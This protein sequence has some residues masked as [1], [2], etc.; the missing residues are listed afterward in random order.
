MK[1]FSLSTF[2]LL[3]TWCGIAAYALSRF[4]VERPFV[5]ST[6]DID[7]GTFPTQFGDI[8][9]DEATV[10]ATRP[11]EPSANNPPVSPRQVLVI[12]NGYFSE[13]LKDSNELAWELEEL[14]L[15]PVRA[16]Q[17]NWCWHV[18]FAGYPKGATMGGV[19]YD[20]ELFINMDG[21]IMPPKIDESHSMYD[22][23]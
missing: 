19:P 17:N 11:W 10:A 16:E 1:Q 15:L 4:L 13:N 14:A 9:F 20:E 18:R 22:E 5:G 23:P 12:A 21:E 2:L 6:A 8:Q 7:Y 3:G